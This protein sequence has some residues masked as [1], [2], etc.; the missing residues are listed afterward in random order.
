MSMR[1]RY[2]PLKTAAPVW[3]LG[4]RLERPKPIVT[5]TLLG[6]TN[7]LPREA[8]LDTGADDTVFHESVAV[9]VGVDLT[10]APTGQAS[11]VGG[12]IVAVRYALVKLRLTDGQEFREWP[13]WV[14]FTAVPLRRGLLGFAGCR[15]FFDANFRGAR[16]EV[17]LIVNS[18]YP[19]T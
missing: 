9:A 3:P 18:L 12:A 1:F 16:E 14:A 13:A 15:Q 5:A 6:P 2:T 4:G 8:L 19:G 7:A 10:G 17:E 11:V